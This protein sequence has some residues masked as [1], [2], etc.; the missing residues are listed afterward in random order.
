MTN[1]TPHTIGPAGL[2]LIKTSEA[3][4]LAAYLCPANRLTIGW[5]HVLLPK[6]DAGLFKNVSP[7]ALAR[8]VAECQRRKTVTREAKRLLYINR[9][10]AEQLLAKDAGRV[11]VFINSLTHAELS[12]SRFDAL[13]SF[14]FNVGDRNYATSTLRA[15]LNAGDFSG[16][17]AEFDRWI[18]GTVDGKKLKLA[19]LITRRAAERALFEAL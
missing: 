10:Q 18:Y 15:K 4:E 13:C 16:A 3:L 12:Q 19:G 8:I 9:R 6:F 11:A 7:E 5:G 14:A 1:T 17:A 2:A